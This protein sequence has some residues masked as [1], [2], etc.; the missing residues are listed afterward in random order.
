MAQIND[1]ESDLGDLDY[2][3]ILQTDDE[4]T[5]A[6]MSVHILNR[7]YKHNIIMLLHIHKYV[8]RG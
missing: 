5:T 3:S 4:N 6:V 2:V 1:I 7:I 8:A